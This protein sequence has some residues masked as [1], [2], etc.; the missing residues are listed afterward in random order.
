MNFVNIN[1]NVLNIKP[2]GFDN[3]K[4]PPQRKLTYSVHSRAPRTLLAYSCFMGCVIF[5]VSLHYNDAIMSAM[6]SPITSLTIVYSTVCSFADQRKHQSSASLTF[7]RGIHRRPVNSPHKRPVTRK[8]FPFDDVIMGITGASVRLCPGSLAFDTTESKPWLLSVWLLRW[9]TYMTH[10]C[11]SK[12]AIISSDNGLSSRQ[13]Q[14]FIWTDAGILLIW[15]LG[16]SF[17]EILIEK[18]IFHSR[19]CIWKWRRLRNSVHFVSGSM[20]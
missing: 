20:C 10:I 19:K 2:H 15:L 7:V 11:F 3:A 12:L 6:A 4:H 16:T 17:S 18:V 13:R 14:A 1:L 5:Y 9:V 8:R